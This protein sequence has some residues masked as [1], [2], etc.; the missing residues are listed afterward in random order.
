MP[1]IQL[2][3][4]GC[5]TA[6]GEGVSFVELGKIKT[7]RYCHACERAVLIVIEGI[8]KLHTGLA[9]EWTDG[10]GT[11]RKLYHDEFP[12]AVLPDE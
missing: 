11:I 7:K 2:C 4:G 9:N 5:G 12:K 8:D 1:I 10:V 3:D 6:E